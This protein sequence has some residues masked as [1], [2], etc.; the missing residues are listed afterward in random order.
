MKM[1]LLKPN[2]EMHLQS[3]LEAKS[4]NGVKCKWREVKA[5]VPNL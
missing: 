2:N 4:G 1:L 3:V 5:L